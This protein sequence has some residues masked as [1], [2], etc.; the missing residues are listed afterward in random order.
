MTIKLSI[1]A[2]HTSASGSERDLAAGTTPGELGIA[3]E[4]RTLQTFTVT[5]DTEVL[6][7]TAK[8]VT[9]TWSGPTPV[10][11]P[12]GGTQWFAADKTA[13]QPTGGGR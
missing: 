8:G 6:Q 1:I 11:T 7:S 3:A 2:H 10:E 4:G 12:G 9:D 5:R 13:F